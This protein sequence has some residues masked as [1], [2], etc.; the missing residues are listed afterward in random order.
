MADKMRL[1]QH[2]ARCPSVLR[3]FLDCNPIYWCFIPLLWDQALDDNVTYLRDTSSRDPELDNIVAMG[4][5]DNYSVS[6]YLDH[7]PI[8]PAAYVFSY[9]QLRKQRLFFEQFVSSSI[10]QPPYFTLD[11][12]KMAVIAVCK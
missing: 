5:V 3:S 7:V 11:L 6:R 8:P 4:A 1:Y 12:Y 10:E 9:R 2:S